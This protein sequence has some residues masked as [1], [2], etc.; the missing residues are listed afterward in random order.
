[1]ISNFLALTESEIEQIVKA[2]I[3][4]DQIYDSRRAISSLRK[5]FEKYRS[6]LP[7]EYHTNMI[8]SKY[9]D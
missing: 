6:K 8:L 4:N 7:K 3:K 5:L 9:I 2:V 1:M